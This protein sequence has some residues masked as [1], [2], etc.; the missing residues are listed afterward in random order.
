[1][2]VHASEGGSRWYASRFRRYLLAGIGPVL[3]AGT[4][5]LISFGMLRLDAPAAFGIFTF[6]FVAAQFTVALSAAL[7]GA[8]LQAL[9]AS[10]S[11]AEREDAAASIV[12]AAVMM[13]AVTGGAFVLLSFAMGLWGQASLWYG[14]YSATMILR[15]LGRSWCYAHD[16]PVRTALSDMIYAVVALGTFG[17]AISSV[18]VP[19]SACYAAL[20]LGSATSLFAFG[21]DFARMLIVRPTR[22]AWDVYRSIWQSQSRW[23]LLGVA[24]TEAVANVHI[25]MV[26]LVA[27][28][29]AMAPLAAAALMFRPINVVQNALAEFER[30]QMARLAAAHDLAEL[31]RT[32]RLFQGVLLAI[33]TASSLLALGV[34]IGAPWLVFSAAYDLTI[35]GTATSLWVIVTLLILLQV[36]LNVMLQATGDFQPLAQATVW[37]SMVSV[38]GVAL[39]LAL[40]DPVWTIAAMAVGWVVDL[41]LVRRA[42]GR[43]WHLLDSGASARL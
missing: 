10:R 9:P 34:L 28:A 30:P 16:R 19:E 22:R 38:G 15:W 26:T 29:E 17:I 23:A 27:G 40:F 8:P 6:L 32:K 43:R 3:L 1:M 33:W 18:R 36:P 5:F 35:V 21:S 37:S 20:A 14:L 39:V 4:H 42:A 11:A 24:T 25:Y 12:T 7:F 2:T 41:I 13:A 31:R